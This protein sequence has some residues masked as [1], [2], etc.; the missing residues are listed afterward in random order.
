MDETKKKGC[1]KFNINY[2]K[3]NGKTTEWPEGASLC[4]R[5]GFG[6]SKNCFKDE[7]D[8]KQKER[9]EAERARTQ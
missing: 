1:E 8:R 3:N 5:V 7:L 9:E 4:H 2:I 6:C